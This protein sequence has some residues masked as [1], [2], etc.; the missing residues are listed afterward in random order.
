MTPAN[1]SESLVNTTSYKSILQNLFIQN[2]QLK[3]NQNE[4]LELAMD[5]NDILKEL[6]EKE[7]ELDVIFAEIFTTLQSIEQ[8][9]K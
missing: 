2:E 5:K 6:I 1:Y 3:A 4:F 9:G 7:K 8:E